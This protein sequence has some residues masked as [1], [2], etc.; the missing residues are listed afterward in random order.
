MS[1]FR[2]LYPGTTDA[3]NFVSQQ[4]QV[5]HVRVRGEDDPR[6]QE[7]IVSD[8]KQQITQFIQR[9]D[10]Q[11]RLAGR[12][13]SHF[14]VEQDGVEMQYINNTGQPLVY[15]SPLVEE[16][17]EPDLP[18]EEE[19]ETGFRAFAVMQYIGLPTTLVT[20]GGSV[21][22]EAPEGEEGS[23]ELS[24][25]IGP[26]RNATAIIYVGNV[27]AS[28]KAEWAAQ[29]DTADTVA[30]VGGM[31]FEEII[32]PGDPVASPLADEFPVFSFDVSFDVDGSEPVKETSEG[33]VDFL[34]S[35]CAPNGAREFPED[36]TGWPS[37]K[38]ITSQ[39][40]PAHDGGG[41]VPMTPENTALL[42]TLNPDTV[43]I[44]T[45]QVLIPQTTGL[46]ATENYTSNASL[47]VT[48]YLSGPLGLFEVGSG[49]VSVAG[50]D[51]V[52]V[53]PA[54]ENRAG[55]VGTI[56]NDLNDIWEEDTSGG[57]ITQLTD[58]RGDEVVEP[59][60]VSTGTTTKEKWSTADANLG[61]APSVSA[62]D[63]QAGTP[64]P[65]GAPGGPV[66]PEEQDVLS[67]SDD[68]F[69][70]DAGPDNVNGS[71]IFRFSTTSSG[72]FV[73]TDF[74]GGLT[75]ST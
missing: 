28:V 74:G 57:L 42:P 16:A 31:T 47:S 23:E 27:P 30:T 53:S 71:V 72:W 69:I 50:A 59:G 33:P 73:D 2:I 9:A 10:N 45:S 13:Y 75:A 19:E 51:K 8:R 12:Q 18:E 67:A 7:Q 26:G 22:I 43:A 17:T 25:E 54:T 20:S 56:W 4:M 49:S 63:Y 34:S 15:I 32:T 61:S 41:D 3:E 14:R 52:D 39:G 58:F 48:V 68:G 44:C 37:F 11:H 62:E 5:A 21:T 64:L 38:S 70:N 24:D 65:P 36:G 60:V 29:A 40:T 46:N 1:D 66:E 6:K 55:A 35:T